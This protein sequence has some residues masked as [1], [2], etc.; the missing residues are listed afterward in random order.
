MNLKRNTFRLY[1]NPSFWEGM[2]R[3][4]DCEGL[5]NQYNYSSSDDEA[6]FKAIRSDW[7]NVGLDLLTAMS[8]FERD[9]CRRC[10]D[11]EQR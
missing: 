4:V 5:L 1:A 6:D 10:H 2:A 7:E 8:H 9:H 3:L 11:G